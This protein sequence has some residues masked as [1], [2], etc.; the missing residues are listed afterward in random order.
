MRRVLREAWVQAGSQ[1]RR[2]RGKGAAG[3]F[4]HLQVASESGAESILF[5][6]ATGVP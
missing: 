5:A 6:E 2:L 1:L 4:E 3:L